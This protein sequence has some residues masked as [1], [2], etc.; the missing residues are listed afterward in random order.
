MNYPRLLLTVAAAKWLWVRPRHTRSTY[1]APALRSLYPIYAK[2]ADAYKKETGVG[3]GYQS[4][5]SG[6]GIPQ[7]KARCSARRPLPG[8][9]LDRIRAAA[10]FPGGNRAPSPG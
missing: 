9:E 6:G 8:K 5:S 2:R 3:L 4:I 10:Q 1:P 7:I